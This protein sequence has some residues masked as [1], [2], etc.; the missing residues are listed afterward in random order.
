[1]KKNLLTRKKSVLARARRETFQEM[2][3][4]RTCFENRL[5][6][7][8]ERNEMLMDQIRQVDEQ[9]G[10]SDAPPP[11]PVEEVQSTSEG[12]DTLL[13]D[14]LNLSAEV[15]FGEN[16][17]QDVD[18]DLDANPEDEGD[19]NKE[20]IHPIINMSPYIDLD[21]LIQDSVWKF[22]RKN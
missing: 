1:M 14:D 15:S 22:P 6:G 2:D 20:N 11:P 4:L 10:L 3:A 7:L 13:Y 19:W 18:S 21:A 16:P 5:A 12:E 9:L 8:N 17:L